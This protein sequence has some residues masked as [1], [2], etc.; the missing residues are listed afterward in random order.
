MGI[1]L[2]QCVIYFSYRKCVV[3]ELNTIIFEI[4]RPTKIN[5]YRRVFGLLV[6]I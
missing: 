4:I 6:D 2:T 1:I 3:E 5:K